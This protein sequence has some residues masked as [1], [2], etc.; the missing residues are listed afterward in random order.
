MISRWYAGWW[1]DKKGRIT[2]IYKQIMK[3]QNLTFNPV[4]RHFKQ[5]KEPAD[6][7]NPA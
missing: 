7:R 4:G 1:R 3:T 5:I 6:S 2:Y